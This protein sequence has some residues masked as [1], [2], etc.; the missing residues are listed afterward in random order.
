VRRRAARVGTAVSGEVPY[1]IRPIHDMT[2]ARFQID[3]PARRMA[4]MDTFGMVI[5]A[6][7]AFALLELAAANLRGEERHARPRKSPAARR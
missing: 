6:I 7:S 4:A 5:L 1:V 2:F 3:R